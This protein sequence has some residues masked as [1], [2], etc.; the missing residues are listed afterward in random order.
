MNLANSDRSWNVKFC[1]LCALLSSQGV[2]SHRSKLL[3]V[4][5]CK[6]PAKKSLY[7]RM[8]DSMLLRHFYVFMFCERLCRQ[9]KFICRNYPLGL[10]RVMHNTIQVILYLLSKITGQ[11]WKYILKGQTVGRDILEKQWLWNGRKFVLGVLAFYCPNFSL[12]SDNFS[13]NYLAQLLV[14]LLCASNACW[15]KT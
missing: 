1:L 6:P 9:N 11:E 15:S 10:V 3:N 2:R 7:V 14:L 5:F 13:Q 12:F 8:Y 4:L